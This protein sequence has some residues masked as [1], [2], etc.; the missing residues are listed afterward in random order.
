MAVAVLLMTIEGMFPVPLATKSVSLLPA[1]MEAFH[2][3]ETDGLLLNP[4][5]VTSP[6]ATP[7]HTISSLSLR[8]AWGWTSAPFRVTCTLSSIN[9]RMNAIAEHRLSASGVVLIA[10]EELE[11]LAAEVNFRVAPVCMSFCVN[12]FRR[13]NE[14]AWVASMGYASP[15]GTATS[16]VPRGVHCDSRLIASWSDVKFLTPTALRSRV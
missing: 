12:V 16:M 1:S 14:S 9:S 8:R 2:L 7:E 4:F 6:V 15:A 13:F 10:M 5:K 3:T 11:S